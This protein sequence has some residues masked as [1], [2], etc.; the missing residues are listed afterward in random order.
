MMFDSIKTKIAST[1]SS[2]SRHHS[3]IPQKMKKLQQEWQADLLKPTFL[4]R[5][6]SDMAIYRLTIATTL[7]GFVINLYYIN[8]LRMKFR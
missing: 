1:S 3:T 6:A 8:E 7:I 2:L 4:L 5:G